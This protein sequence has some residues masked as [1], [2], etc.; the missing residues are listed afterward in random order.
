MPILLVLIHVYGLLRFVGFNEFLFSF[1]ETVFIFKMQGILQMNFRKLILGMGVRKLEGIIESLL[2]SLV[3][4]SSVNETILDQELSSFLTFHVFSNLDR[5]LSQ[6]FG[7]AVCFSNPE[8]IFPHLMSSIH[9]D[10]D[11]PST[12][13]DI[14]VFSLLKIAFNIK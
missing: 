11:L 3:V 6:L 4:N 7:T 10:T 1:F 9:I 13:F 14:V 12:T 8:G 5:D 2:V